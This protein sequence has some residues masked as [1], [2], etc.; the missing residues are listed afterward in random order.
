ME[1]WPDRVATRGEHATSDAALF[2]EVVDIFQ[3]Q[4]FCFR[5]EEVDN[6]DLDKVSRLN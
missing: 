3:L 5:E 6:R 4:S 2:E 1:A